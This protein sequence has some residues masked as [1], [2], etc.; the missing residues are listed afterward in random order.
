MWLFEISS[1]LFV[2]EFVHFTLLNNYL[3]LNCLWFSLPNKVDKETLEE[4]DNLSASDELPVIHIS[5]KTVLGLTVWFM[6]VIFLFVM[7]VPVIIS[8]SILRFRSSGS[9]QHWGKKMLE[10][11]A[12]ICS[13]FLGNPSPGKCPSAHS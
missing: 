9:T 3:P 6:Y 1:R 4:C 10:R 5:H 2:R 7:I 8:L 13:D 12:N 11:C